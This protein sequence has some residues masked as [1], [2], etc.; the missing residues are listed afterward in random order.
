[1]PLDNKLKQKIA[2][3]GIL[4]IMFC[5]SAGVVADTEYHVDPDRVTEAFSGISLLRYYSDSLDFVIQKNPVKTEEFL[6]LMPFAHVPQSLEKTNGDFAQSAIA[7]SQSLSEIYQLRDQR[8]EFMMQSRLKEALALSGTILSGIK[9]ARA[10]LIN[11]E[12]AAVLTGDNLKVTAT[13]AQSDLRRTY[14]EVMAKIQ[15]VKSMLDFLTDQLRTDPTNL[16]DFL[17]SGE[18]VDLIGADRLEE[19]LK[20]RQPEDLFQATDLTLKITPLAAFVGDNV[21]YNV[22]LTSKGQPLPGRVVSILLNGSPYITATTDAN[23]RCSGWLALPFWYAP[24]IE[25]QAFYQPQTADFGLYLAS[26]SPTI[27]VQVLFYQANLEVSVVGKGYPGKE[28]TLNGKFDYGASPPLVNRTLGIYLDDALISEVT[29]EVGLTFALPLDPKMRLGQHSVTMSAPA[30]GRYSPA[31]ASATIEVVTAAPV[32]ILSTPKVALIPG[33]IRLSGRVYSELGPLNGATVIIDSGSSHTETTTATDGSY[34]VNLRIGIGLTLIGSQALSIRV[35]P[36]EPW[37]ASL[38]T[39]RQMFAINFVNCT[40]ASVILLF[41]GIYLPRKLGRRLGVYRQRAIGGTGVITRK[42]SSAHSIV[43]VKV[44]LPSEVNEE[45]GTPRNRVYNWYLQV[46]KLVRKIAGPLPRPQQTMR[47]FAKESG[48]ILG[49]AVRYFME[50][51][52]LVE[53]F[54]YGTKEPLEEDADESQKL[55]QTVQREIEDAAV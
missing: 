38:A 5:G 1:M 27:K 40:V 17:K 31:V 34:D 49:P 30:D 11:L 28:V 46:L 35:V 2:V 48:R 20:T 21:N 43:T 32:M 12:K 15:S 10:E 55:S 16:D 47:E 37:N 42:P 7:V 52:L 25:V 13:P 6:G 24:T 51:T 26:L 29:T 41:L 54:F 39:D 14:D 44:K 9:Q 19:L 23:G 18:L 36:R 3:A 8:S 45:A 4:A 53:R 22:L 33:D 50:L